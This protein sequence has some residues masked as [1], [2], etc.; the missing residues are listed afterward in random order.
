MSLPD[1]STDVPSKSVYNWATSPTVVALI[2]RLDNR[3]FALMRAANA[4]RIVFD[5]RVQLKLISL[6]WQ[7][8]VQLPL[9]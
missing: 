9:H 3:V 2:T 7:E 8:S 6:L 4:S 5:E 1:P